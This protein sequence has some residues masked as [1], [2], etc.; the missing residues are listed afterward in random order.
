MGQPN[1]NEPKSSE[2]NP[3][4]GSS[5]LDQNQPANAEPK[6]GEGQPEPTPTAPAPT[7]PSSVKFEDFPEKFLI[8]GKQDVPKLIAAHADLEKR[9]HA[10]PETYEVVVPEGTPDDMFL[11]ETPADDPLVQAAM[12]F[13][14]EQRLPQSAFDGMV[15]MYLDT[16]AN[17]TATDPVAELAALGEDAKVMIPR[18]KAFVDAHLDKDEQALAKVYTT[19]AQGIKLFDKMVQLASKSMGIPPGTDASAILS[20]PILTVAQIRD[21]MKDE[22]YWNSSDPKYRGLRDEVAEDFKRLNKAA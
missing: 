8:D 4:G 16:V 6:A 18:V 5:L 11:G 1:Q 3:S 10:A 20:R 2:P 12:A 7:E 14:K 9:F 21:K 15:K 17:L 19:T 13:A 22:A